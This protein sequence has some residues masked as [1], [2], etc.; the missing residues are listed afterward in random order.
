MLPNQVMAKFTIYLFRYHVVLR[1]NDFW[2]QASVAEGEAGYKTQTWSSL[3]QTVRITSRAHI[4]VK[5]LEDTDL[6]S[7]NS[8]VPT[9]EV[10]T[11]QKIL[12]GEG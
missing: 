6:P 10:S 5:K 12:M 9:Q 4:S 7:Q 2:Y 8:E 11:Y 3:T 1:N